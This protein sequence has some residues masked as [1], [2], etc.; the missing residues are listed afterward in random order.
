MQGI[1]GL[2]A[3][4]DARVLSARGCSAIVTSA[5]PPTAPRPLP[6][7]PL[8][9]TALRRSAP[10]TAAMMPMS[11]TL[12]SAMTAARWHGSWRQTQRVPLTMRHASAWRCWAAGR[13]G[14]RGGRWAAGRRAG[15]ATSTEQQPAGRSGSNATCKLGCACTTRA[16]ILHAGIWSKAQQ[17]RMLRGQLQGSPVQVPPWSASTSSP[18]STANSSIQHSI[19]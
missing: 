19:S 13:A 8:P 5:C 2:W 3:T 14:G 6:E 12:E 9:P 11:S 7:L 4:W 1:P 18:P 10:T 16:S 17:R 15:A